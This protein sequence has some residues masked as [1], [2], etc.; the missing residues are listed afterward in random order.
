M[1]TRR[2]ASHLH[3]VVLVTHEDK[4]LEAP[5]RHW[6]PRRRAGKKTIATGRD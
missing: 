6:R 5:M 3:F 1:L 4:T 2:V